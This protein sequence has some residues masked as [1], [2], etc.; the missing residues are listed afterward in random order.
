MEKKGLQ[1]SE[2]DG[3]DSDAADIDLAGTTQT[4]SPARNELQTV[5]I[6]LGNETEHLDGEPEFRRATDTTVLDQTLG[7]LDATAEPALQTD[8]ARRSFQRVALP[9]NETDTAFEMRYRAE[10]RGETL[11][12]YLRKS[13]ERS[14]AAIQG[15]SNPY[16]REARELL[17]LDESLDP[18]EVHHL[19][20]RIRAYERLEAMLNAYHNKPEDPFKGGLLGQIV[21]G[22][23][24]ISEGRLALVDIDS[25]AEPVIVDMIEIPRTP[26][27]GL[28]TIRFIGNEALAADAEQDRRLIAQYD[29]NEDV[30]YVDEAFLDGAGDP[31]VDLAAMYQIEL[32]GPNDIRK[33]WSAAVSHEVAHSQGATEYGAEKAF[34]ESLSENGLIAGVPEKAEILE[35]IVIRTR[36]QEAYFAAVLEAFDGE[37]SPEA[38]T[39]LP[40]GERYGEMVAR[41]F[42]APELMETRDSWLADSDSALKNGIAEFYRAKGVIDG[43]ELNQRTLKQFAYFE[44]LRAQL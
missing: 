21:T 4:T 26:R 23:L 40:G 1:T 43:I 31:I 34:L 15:E 12:H 30:L 13:L 33:F 2:G 11:E 17:A 7:P 16:A 37:I 5:E 18:E 19:I 14:F 6:N 27:A 29:R 9:S 25:A 36:R 32:V 10:H 20:T 35:R 41:I 39:W 8:D 28:P 24:E 22:K 42:G 44:Q 38:I 3:V